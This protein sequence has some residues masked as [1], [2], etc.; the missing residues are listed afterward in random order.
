MRPA[1]TVAL[2][3]TLAVTGCVSTDTYRKKEAEAS[4]LRPRTRRSARTSRTTSAKGAMLQEKLKAVQAQVD[5]LVADVNSLKE[6]AHVDEGALSQKEAELRAARQR[7]VELQALVDELSK[8]KRKLEVAKAELEKKSGEYEQLASALRG[9]IRVGPGRAHGAEGPDHR[10]DEGQDPLRL[11]LRHHRP[12]RQGRAEEG[13]RGA[14]LA[15]R[16]AHPRRGAHRQRPDRPRRPVPD[17]LGAAPRARALAV[18]RFLQESGVDA[19]PDLRGRV[20]R[21]TS[22]SPRTTRP[23]GGASTGASRSCSS[24][25]RARSRPRRRRRP[26]RTRRRRPSKP[27]KIPP[28]PPPGERV[29]GEGARGPYRAPSRRHPEQVSP[30]RRRR[31]SRRRRPRPAPGAGARSDARW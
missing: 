23:R 17:Q 1:A 26:S 10:E 25:S 24:R 20:R 29:G 30:A 21:V 8:S 15:P 16:Q 14:P 12:G 7:V 3:L 18:V 6:K 4:K 2:A 13:R 22:P 5:T 27:L 31:C 9:E 19:D 28:S 11:G